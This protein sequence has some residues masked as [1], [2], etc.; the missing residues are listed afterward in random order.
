MENENN[1]QANDI[2]ISEENLNEFIRKGDELIAQRKEHN[3]LTEDKT[4]STSKDVK[5]AT[6]IEKTAGQTKPPM[7]IPNTLNIADIKEDITKRKTAI[8][9]LTDAKDSITKT[10]DC[11]QKRHWSK[12]EKILLRKVRAISNELGTIIEQLKIIPEQQGGMAE[13]QQQLLEQPITNIKVAYAKGGKFSVINTDT[14][15]TETT[16]N[17][18]EIKGYLKGIYTRKQATE[19]KE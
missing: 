5:Q 7:N 15:V 17:K 8:K 2:N 11:N 6:V 4:E 18:D 16:G 14:E 12:E 1:S 9:Y 10:L 19:Q 13:I 3:I